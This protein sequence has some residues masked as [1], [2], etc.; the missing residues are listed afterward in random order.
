[1]E[2][3]GGAAAA[4]EVGLRFDWFIL[5]TKYGKRRFYVLLRLETRELDHLDR[6]AFQVPGVA[7]EYSTHSSV[8]RAYSDEKMEKI[9]QN[10]PTSRSVCVSWVGL[11]E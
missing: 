1:M 5:P 8:S 11:S 4:R 6:P 3:V 9:Q 7:M 10:T 2:L